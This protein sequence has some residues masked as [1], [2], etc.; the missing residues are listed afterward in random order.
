[1][2][3]P[4]PGMDPYLEKPSSWPGVHLELISGIR[5]A[6]TQQLRPRYYVNV[7]ERIYLSGPND[8][9]RSAWVPDLYLTRQSKRRSRVSAAPSTAVLEV[10][11][12]IV[13][14]TL[15][16]EEIHERYLSSGRPG[17]SVHRQRDRSAQSQQ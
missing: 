11:E 3:S 7:D 6:L 12:P 1:M 2:P 8:P 14:I 5:A 15:L 17:R 10:A 13:A 4:F 9:G 16:D